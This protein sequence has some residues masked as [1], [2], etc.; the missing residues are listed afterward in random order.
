MAPGELALCSSGGPDSWKLSANHAA[1]S[2]AASP[3]FREIGMVHLLAFHRQRSHGSLR[4][5]HSHRNNITNGLF[6]LTGCGNLTFP[7]I[8]DCVC[9]WKHSSCGHE[10]KHRTLKIGNE[11][12]AIGSLSVIV[13]GASSTPLSF[14]AYSSK[15]CSCRKTD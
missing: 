13:K 6:S 7:S 9:W 12:F 2:R 5:R 10:A 8:R 3:S 1:H 15:Y 4:G 11:N 14:G